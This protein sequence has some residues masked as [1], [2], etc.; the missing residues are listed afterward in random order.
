MEGGEK[1]FMV[2]IL[3][4]MRFNTENTISFMKEEIDVVKHYSPDLPVTTNFMH[5]YPA[6][7]YNKM[8]KE[9][10]IISWDSYPRY[11]T[12]DESLI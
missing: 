10:D 6:L 11:N 1:Q 4:G 2:L 3:T 7:D 8:S 12:P 5:L 9:L